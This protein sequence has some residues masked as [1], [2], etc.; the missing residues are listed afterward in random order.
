MAAGLSKSL[1]PH[2]RVASA[3]VRAGD[4]DPFLGAVMQE[5]GIDLVDHRPV[6]LDELRP[7]GFDL[8]ITLSPEAHHLVLELTR[9]SDLEVEYWPTFDPTFVEGS[10]EQIMEAYRSLRDGLMRRIQARFAE[11]SG[12]GDSPPGVSP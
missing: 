6:S 7:E 3:G 2:L 9:S 8:A 5:V 1:W 10:R 4:K 11:T 12:G